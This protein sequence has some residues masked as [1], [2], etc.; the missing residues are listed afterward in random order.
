[1]DVET[2]ADRFVGIGI[3]K[4]RVDVHI[5]PSSNGFGCATSAEGLGALVERLKPLSPCLVVLAVSGGYEG[6]VAAAL[7]ESRPAGG[8]RQPAPGA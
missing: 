4:A 3:S 2:T 5:R 8:K 7:V 1:M 6:V